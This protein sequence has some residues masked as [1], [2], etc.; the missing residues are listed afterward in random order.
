MEL[1][2]QHL[3]LIGVFPDKVTIDIDFTDEAVVSGAGNLQMIA[4]KS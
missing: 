2:Y 4:N 1:K 3:M